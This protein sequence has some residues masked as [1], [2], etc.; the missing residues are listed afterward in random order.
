MAILHTGIVAGVAPGA[1]IAGFV[2][3]HSGASA[4]YAVALAG[5]VL[6]ALVAQTA[7]QAPPIP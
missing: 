5:G 1:S 2:V 4:A 7:R 6:G 3:D